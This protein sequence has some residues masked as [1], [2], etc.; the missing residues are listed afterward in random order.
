MADRQLFLLPRPPRST[1]DAQRDYPLL[2]DWMYSLYRAITAYAQTQDVSELFNPASLP[3]PSRTNIA[4]AQLTANQSYTL[5]NTAK[6]LANAAQT[7]ANTGVTNAAAAQATAT[8][9]ASAAATAQSTATTANN[10]TAD[11]FD[12][13]ATVNAG[14]TTG[15]FTFGASEPD[16]NYRVL[17]TA[18]SKTGTP[19]AGSETIVSITKA[20]GSLTINVA[21]DPGVGNSVTF[22][23]LVVRFP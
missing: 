3:D 23:I 11:W 9:A 10:R 19:N 14:G 16:A 5:A 18:V 21:A 2:V 6:N 4:T 20:T 1:G 22:D 12:G 17:A 7:T 15:V 8:A 13:S